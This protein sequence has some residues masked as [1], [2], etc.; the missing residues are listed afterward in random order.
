[1]GACLLKERLF[2]FGG[3]NGERIQD[4][5]AIYDPEKRKWKDLPPMPYPRVIMGA[6]T[7]RETAY[8]LG[9]RGPDGKQPVDT[10]MALTIS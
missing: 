5:V 3:N 8:L 9:G 2:V 10:V 1:V 6:V 7:V 4:R